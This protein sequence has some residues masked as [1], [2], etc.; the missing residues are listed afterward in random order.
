MK[1]SPKKKTVAIV[2][3]RYGSTRFPG[4]MLAPILGKPLLQHTLENARRCQA[5][6]ELWVATDDARIFELATS[7]G[8]SA[9]M[10]PSE[11]PN[12]T[13]RVAL[14]LEHL[15]PLDTIGCV[16]N[17]QGDDPAFTPSLIDQLVLALDDSNAVIA[18]ACTPIYSREDFADPSVVKCV[19]S[20]SGQ[21]IYFSRS[22]IPFAHKA[23]APILGYQHIG[24]YAFRP[25]FLSLYPTLPATPLQQAEDLEQLKVL[26]H[27]YTIR[28]VTTEEPVVG[29]NLPGDIEKLERLLCRQNTSS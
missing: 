12:G 17:V 5:I 18:T 20:L 3:A 14:V 6:D 21:A 24:I 7:L 27:G 11:C 13:A 1:S 4:K 15:G 25:D 9:L 28:M 16:I 19:F 2:P 26:E 29:V 10:T 23:T 8:V 22:P